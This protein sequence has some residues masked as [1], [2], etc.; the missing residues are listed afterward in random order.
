MERNPDL[1]ISLRRFGRTYL[2]DIQGANIPKRWDQ[3]VVSQRG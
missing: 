3:Y 2:S 1:V